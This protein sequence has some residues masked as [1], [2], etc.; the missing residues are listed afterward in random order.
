MEVVCRMFPWLQRTSPPAM[1]PASSA[2]MSRSEKGVEPRRVLPA[3]GIQGS[4]TTAALTRVFPWELTPRLASA[5][6]PA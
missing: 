3:V 2:R 4:W 5:I 6:T 1:E